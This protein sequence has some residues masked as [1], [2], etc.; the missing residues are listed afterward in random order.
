MIR[1]IFLSVFLVV[2]GSAHAESI[3]IPD[4]YKI[5]T[6]VYGDGF[7]ILDISKGTTGKDVA[8]FMFGGLKEKPKENEIWMTQCFNTLNKGLTE[9]KCTIEQK[10]F[11]VG[12]KSHEKIAVFNKKNVSSK[13]LHEVNYK[14][15]GGSIVTEKYQLL[16]PYKTENLL[17]QLTTANKFSYSW[18]GPKGYITQDIYM[19]GF[20]ESYDFAKRMVE[21]NK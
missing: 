14:I 6:E 8:V 15:D 17:R 13:N 19:E 1:N 11:Y 3:I 9:F 4:E 5:G 7:Y 12:L 16:T 20:K 2:V 18:K 10:D 21:V